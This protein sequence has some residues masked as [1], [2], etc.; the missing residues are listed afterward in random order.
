[1]I[2]SPFS[3]D[4]GRPGMDGD[5]KDRDFVQT[6]SNKKKKKKSLIF[7]HKIKFSLV[8][9][10]RGPRKWSALIRRLTTPLTSRRC[11]HWSDAH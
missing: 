8:G 7:S 2:R 6:G 11:C 1:M 9:L 5:R 3:L 10:C 4:V